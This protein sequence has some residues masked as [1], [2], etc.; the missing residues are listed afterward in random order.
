MHTTGKGDKSAPG[1]FLLSKSGGSATLLDFALFDHINR[2][3]ERAKETSKSSRA[4]TKLFP[5]KILIT[6]PKEGPALQKWSKQIGKD[7]QSIKL[8]QNK[9]TIRRVL[10]RN[11][12]VLSSQNDIKA[13]PLMERV[14]YHSYLLFF[15]FFFFLQASALA[16]LFSNGRLCVQVFAVDEA[17]KMV[18]WAVS[19]YLMECESKGMEVQKDGNKLLLPSSAIDYSIRMLDRLQP[20]SKQA[21]FP[22]FFF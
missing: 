15:F 14:L 2:M 7:R 4:L 16:V 22:L 11:N 17:E 21:F 3:E 20:I 12:I 19:H 9:S 13:R 8:Q 18:G 6:P 10:E 5:N 1:S